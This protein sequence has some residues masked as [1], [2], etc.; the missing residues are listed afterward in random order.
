M[1]AGFGAHVQLVCMESGPRVDQRYES[2]NENKLVAPC[3]SS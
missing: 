1:R 3:V 2:T